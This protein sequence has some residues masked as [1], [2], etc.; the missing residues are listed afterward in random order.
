MS[1][2]KTAPRACAMCGE[3]PDVGDGS[4]WRWR[5]AVTCPNYDGPPDKGE[6]FTPHNRCFV[7]HSPNEAVKDWNKF[8]DEYEA[9]HE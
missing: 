4:A 8:N 2:R 1:K 6:G 7:G 3:M 5:Y 9:S